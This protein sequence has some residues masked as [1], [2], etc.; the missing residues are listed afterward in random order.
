[1]NL[2]QNSTDFPEIVAIFLFSRA[3]A[4]GIRLLEDQELTKHFSAQAAQPPAQLLFLR[5]GVSHMLLHQGHHLLPQGRGSFQPKQ[6]LIRQYG[7][8]LGV[9]IKMPLALAVQ[10]KCTGLS[11]IVQQRR[12]TQGQVPFHMLHHMGGVGVN[13]VSMVV[14][15]LVKAHQGSQFR[16]H[17]GNDRR[18]GQQ[19]LSLRQQEKFAQLLKNPFPGQILHQ[20]CQVKHGFPGF[21]LHLQP[22]P[23]GKAHA[24]QNPQAVLLKPLFRLAHR[25][26]DAI[27]QI[28]RPAKGIAQT[29]QGGI[30]HGVDGEIPP[31]QILLDGGH[32]ADLL[33][34]AIVQIV[35]L[36]AEGG[37]LHHA[38]VRNNAHGA[39]LLSRQHLGIVGE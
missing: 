29:T 1:M 7:T 8:F 13:I 22:K 18:K 16:D 38:V 23:H 34:M 19:I 28:L 9:S 27:F 37:D 10:C 35:P 32:K 5:F 3:F 25:P 36:G 31:G 2:L 17:L 14:A 4:A 15:M 20:G 24:S 21:F 30:G 12:P 11:C 26:E 6:D 39:M 33:G